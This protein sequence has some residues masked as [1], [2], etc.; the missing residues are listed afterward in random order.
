MAVRKK[1]RMKSGDFALTIIVLALVVFGVIMVFS[2]SYYNALNDTGDPR[3]SEK[4]YRMG[5]V[6]WAL[7][8]FVQYSP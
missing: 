4:R 3:L 6:D 7:C 1:T 5:N 8:C 2:S